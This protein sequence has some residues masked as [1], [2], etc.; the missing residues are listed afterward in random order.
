MLADANN[1]SVNTRHD[2]RISLAGTVVELGFIVAASIMFN[3]FPEKVGFV[4]SLAEP[5]SFTPLLAPEFQVHLPLLNLC[6][7]LG[8]SL[9]IANLFTQRWTVVTRCIQVAL[10]TLGILVLIELVL[11]GPLTIY[12]WLDLALKF[13]LAMAI[14]PAI[15]DAIKHLAYLLDGWEISAR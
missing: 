9:S 6:W 2:D 15:I 12:G 8:F 4:R 5:D 7:G 11:G 3:M 1:T 13:G 10:S 14:I